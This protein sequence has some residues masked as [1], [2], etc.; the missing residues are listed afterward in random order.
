[1]RPRNIYNLTYKSRVPYLRGG[2]HA[3]VTAYTT[4]PV[5]PLPGRTRKRPASVGGGE[6]RGFVY[7]GRP[8]RI[9]GAIV[10]P[11]PPPLFFRAA[12]R[13]GNFPITAS[14]RPRASDRI[15]PSYRPIYINFSLALGYY[16]YIH[17][18]KI[19]RTELHDAS[20]YTYMYISL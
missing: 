19:R 10:P 7:R 4:R 5:L 8:G 16:I 2:R 20:K 14:V 18:H 15:T 9:F 17:T 6:G 12:S 3:V 1:M 13:Y 11:P